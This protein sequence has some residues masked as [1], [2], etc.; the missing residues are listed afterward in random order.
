LRNTGIVN[1]AQ[2]EVFGSEREEMTGD[3]RKL[4]REKLVVY[5]VYPKITHM[6]VMKSWRIEWAGRVAG[7]AKSEMHVGLVEKHARRG[8]LV[9]TGR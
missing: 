3:G 4:L 9:R 6:W 8:L 7:V 1:R 5:T 2:R